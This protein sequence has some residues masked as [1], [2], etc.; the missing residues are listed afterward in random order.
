MNEVRTTDF[1][2]SRSRSLRWITASVVVAV[3]VLTGVSAFLFDVDRV[4]LMTAALVLFALVGVVLL[5]A[6]LFGQIEF[7]SLALN[8]L[9]RSNGHPMWPLFLMS[10]QAG[11]AISMQA[12]GS[13]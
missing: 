8:I 12:N 3:L 13:P 5:L 1:S 6:V 9:A 10:S 7:S 4:L 11:I 2:E